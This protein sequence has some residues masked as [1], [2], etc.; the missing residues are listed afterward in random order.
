MNSSTLK[1]VL[2]NVAAGAIAFAAA[3]A[4]NCTVPQSFGLL[5]VAGIGL[6]ALHDYTPRRQVKIALSSAKPVA[7]PVVRRRVSAL[8]AA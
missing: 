7:R 4:L 8:V 2:F 1:N 3:R 5:A 6:I